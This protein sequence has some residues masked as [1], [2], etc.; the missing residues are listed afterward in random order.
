[1]IMMLLMLH[2]GSGSRIPVHFP[3]FHPLVSDSHSVQAWRQ[4]D[5]QSD[6]AF[7]GSSKGGNGAACCLR[8]S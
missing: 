2:K 1:M 4:E 5:G 6:E 7:C 8:L 3:H